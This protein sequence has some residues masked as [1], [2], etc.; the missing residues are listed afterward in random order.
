MGGWHAQAKARKAGNAVQ[1]NFQYLLSFTPT[2]WFPPARS[3][4]LG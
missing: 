4:F 1:V 2:L 3:L